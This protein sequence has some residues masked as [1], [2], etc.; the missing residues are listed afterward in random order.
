MWGNGTCENVL[1]THTSNMSCHFSLCEDTIT[2]SLT[3]AEGKQ[4]VLRMKKDRC[5]KARVNYTV[6]DLVLK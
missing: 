6:A 4:L 2:I 5:S 3:V 1:P